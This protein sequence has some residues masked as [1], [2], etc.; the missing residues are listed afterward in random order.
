MLQRRFAKIRSKNSK[1]AKTMSLVMTLA[2]TIAFSAATVVMAVSQDDGLEHWDKNEIYYLSGIKFS[3]DIGNNPIPD[4]AEEFAGDNGTVDVN[5]GEYAFRDTKGNIR[6]S[7]IG[8]FSSGSNILRLSQ[9]VS[10]L[11]YENRY[12]MNFSGLPEELTNDFNIQPDDGRHIRITFEL[13]DEGI[14]INPAMEFLELSEEM[15]FD[16]SE[17]ADTVFRPEKADIL[18]DFDRTYLNIVNSVSD[19]SLFLDFEKN[20]Y[21]NRTVNGIDVEILYAANDKMVI[22]ADSQ[23]DEIKNIKASVYN[24]DG[25]R[26]SSLGGIQKDE[27]GYKAKIYNDSTQA[28]VTADGKTITLYAPKPIDGRQSSTLKYSDE[29]YYASFISKNTYRIELGMYGENDELIYRWLE[30]ATVQ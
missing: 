26:V 25:H 14:M 4:W 13:D 23:Y 2:L 11:D 30:Y 3:I 10:L 6:N 16:A 19:S 15:N 20:N 5:I 9:T 28:E 17:I 29:E 27:N 18:G 7:I 22:K 21:K 24:A 8:T 12:I 1:I